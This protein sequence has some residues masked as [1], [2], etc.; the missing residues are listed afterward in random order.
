[1]DPN[2]LVDFATHDYD[3]EEAYMDKKGVIQFYTVY[4][5]KYFEIDELKLI[6]LLL[7]EDL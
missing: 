1:M 5:V 4:D 3:I 2:Y 7:G 6:L